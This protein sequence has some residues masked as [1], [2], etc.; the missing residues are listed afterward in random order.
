MLLAV[1]GYTSERYPPEEKAGGRP[2]STVQEQAKSTRTPSPT[3]STKRTSPTTESSSA[4][5]TEETT[6]D[7]ESSTDT[8][9]TR[10]RR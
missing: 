3:S 7:E 6:T 4:G 5:E 1:Y 9:D 8:T 2:V 10:T